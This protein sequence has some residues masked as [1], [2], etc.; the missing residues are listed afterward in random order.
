MLTRREFPGFRAALRGG[1]AVQAGPPKRI[2]LVD[3]NLDNYHAG[4]TWRRC[5][6][7]S[8]I[9]AT[10]RGPAL[11]HDPSRAWRRKNA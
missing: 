10:R 7:R 6:A 9:A 2:G 1:L 5:A 11:Q 8:R 4:S 3:D